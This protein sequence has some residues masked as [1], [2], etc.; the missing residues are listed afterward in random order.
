MGNRCRNPKGNI[1]FNECP[2]E[3][4]DGSCPFDNQVFICSGSAIFLAHAALIPAVDKAG[5]F[6]QILWK[7]EPAESEFGARG[8]R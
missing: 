8:D 2:G 7:A 1:C 5:D 3:S 4:E 6:Y